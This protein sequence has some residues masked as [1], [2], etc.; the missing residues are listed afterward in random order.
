MPKE[1]DQLESMRSPMCS[2]LEHLGMQAEADGLAN[3]TSI[4]HVREAY[5]NAFSEELDVVTLVHGDL[6]SSNMMFRV[7]API[8]GHADIVGKHGRKKT[9]KPLT[10]DWTQFNLQIYTTKN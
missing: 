5:K 7:T 3:L 6:W 4:E 9:C 10:V 2:I 8:Q 1:F